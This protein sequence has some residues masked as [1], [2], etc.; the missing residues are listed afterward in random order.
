MQCEKDAFQ[1]WPTDVSVT[2]LPDF[3]AQTPHQETR[4]FIL[5]FSS[6]NTLA[7]V[8]KRAQ[9]V[10]TV[11]DLRDGSPLLTINVDAGASAIRVVGSTAFVLSA[12][13]MFAWHIPT[14]G[15]GFDHGA[16]TSDSIST[17]RLKDLNE[18]GSLKQQEMSGAPIPPDSHYIAGHICSKSGTLNLCIYDTTTGDWQLPNSGPGGMTWFTPDSSELGSIRG[19]DKLSRWKLSKNGKYWDTQPKDQK[20]TEDLLGWFPWLSTD[21]YKITDDGWILSPSG[22]HLL[23]LPHHWQLG[24]KEE[25]REWSGCYLTLSDYRLPEPVILDL[26]PVMDMVIFRT[27]FFELFSFLHVHAPYPPFHLLTNLGRHRDKA[28]HWYSNGRLIMVHKNSNYCY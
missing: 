22:K 25:T 16:R 8:T 12:G 3:F 19:G 4:D 5:E 11:L 6:P 10:V 21:G 24:K 18:F 2:P 20:L 23:W 13:D 26:C 7:I 15:S 17:I 28:K 9:K 27:I 1:L 14:R